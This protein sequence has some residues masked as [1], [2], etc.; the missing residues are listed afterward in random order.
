MFVLYHTR[1]QLGQYLFAGGVSTCL[2]L[3][4]AGVASPILLC[5]T[6]KVKNISLSVFFPAYNEEQNIKKTVE[7]AQTVLKKVVKTYEIIIVDDGSSDKTGSIAD[8]L[9]KADPN[10]IRVI[11]HKPNQGYGAALQSGFETAQYDYVFFSDSDLQF[12][13]SEI[14]KLLKFVPDYQ[15]VVGYRAPRRDPFFR[16]VNAKIL[17][18]ANRL[19]FGLTIR[20]VD[21]AFKLF[22]RDEVKNIEMHARGAMLSTELMV[23]L[24]RA[25]TKIKEV[26]VTHLPNNKAETT[27][28][29]PAVIWRAIKEF[30]ALFH[31]DLATPA[32]RQFVSFSLIGALNTVGDF[33]LYVFLTRTTPFF[34]DHILVAKAVTF[35]TLSISSFFLNRTYTFKMKHQPNWREFSRFFA[36]AGTGLIVNVTATFV[37]LRLVRFHDLLAVTGAIFF[38]YAWNFSFQKY[39]V[40]RE[41]AHKH[42]IHRT[43]LLILL[44]LIVA[45]TINSL[46]WLNTD[47]MPP[48]WDMANHLRHSLEYTDVASN[49]VN[50]NTLYDLMKQCYIFFIGKNTYYPPFAYWVSVPFILTLGRTYL[51]AVLSNLFFLIVISF[52]TYT[53][54]TQLWNR[55]TGRLAT[56]VMLTFPYIIGQFHEFQ[57]DM[58]LTAMTTLAM[59]ALVKSKGFSSP[60]WSFIFGVAFGLGMLTKWPVGAFLI[61]PVLVTLLSSRIYGRLSWKQLGANL[62]WAGLGFIIT[63]GPWYG[64][65]LQSLRENL[66]VNW[67]TGTGEGDPSPFSPDSLK[68]YLVVLTQWQIRLPI[69][70]P[71]CIGLFLSCF[72]RRHRQK[73]GLILAWFLGG[74]LVMTFY[75][76]KDFRFIEPVLP[77]IA[78]LATYWISTLITPWRRLWVGFILVVA[79]FQFLSVSWGTRLFPGLPPTVRANVIGINPDHFTLLVYAFDGYGSGPPR[80]Q[81]WHQNEVIE[82]IKATRDT[83][84][85]TIAMYYTDAPFF[86]RENIA[87][88][89]TQQKLPYTI[90]PGGN[91]TFNCLD[92]DIIIATDRNTVAKT[93]EREFPL[94]RAFRL[95]DP[96]QPVDRPLCNLK[97]LYQ[98]TLPNRDTVF[99]WQTIK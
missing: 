93:V 85:T 69:L 88:T 5:Y 77:A 1:G 79:L 13:L 78:L 26:P 24:K 22:K 64:V 10:H 52:G 8:D 23:R 45:I 48:H 19:A 43:D 33:S 11:H 39:W 80:I 54:G 29:K 17:A 74:Y 81:N 32:M 72:F 83:Q 7:L 15:A 68:Y 46:I 66:G 86:N 71:A 70:I 28:A 44:S 56:I 9:Q 27:G 99:V 63:A 12:D 76:N 96:Q 61:A 65:H 87:Y 14:S 53:L 41:K 36:T 62:M 90:A 16:I 95:K 42:G 58:P 6:E 34:H 97:L 55:T 4:L 2:V 98:T 91:A 47:T 57:L 21:C 18:L 50:S 60:G 30:I 38:S 73:N 89:I 59:V 49:I 75:N 31:G 25:G 67:E 37:L 3:S 82:A 20:D 92:I 40:F 35:V 94:Y 84:S 51:A